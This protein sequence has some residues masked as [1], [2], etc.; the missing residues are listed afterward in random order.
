MLKDLSLALRNIRR[1]KVLTAINVLG[2]SIGISAC[3]AIFLIASYEL[4]FDKFQP[5]KDRI[6]RIYSEF[7]G[8]FK[9]S[10]R[11]VPT[12]VPVAIRDHL[13]GIESLTNFHNFF[14]CHVKIPVKNSPP[15]DFGKYKKVII[16]APDYFEVF[17]YYEWIVGNPK[18]SLSQPFNVVI[19][20]SRAMMYFGVAD[21]MSVIGKEI[22]YQDSLLV[23]V[24]GVVKDIRERTDLDFTDFISLST[25]ERSWLKDNIELNSWNNVS[26]SSQLFV[27]LAAG[28]PPEKIE[29]ELLRLPEILVAPNEKWDDWRPAAR[30]QPFDELHF[31][32]KL[33]VFDSSRTVMDQSTIYIL[34]GVAAL[35]LFTGII[36][37]INLQTAQ[38]SVHAKEVGI[39][40]LM[41]SSRTKLISRFLSQSLILCALAVILSVPSVKLF[42]NYFPDYIPE[43]LQFHLADPAIILFLVSC[44]IAVTFLAGLYPAFVMSSYQPA[45][46]L[47][48][49]AHANTGS[50]RSSFIRKSLTLSQFSFSQIFLAGALVIALQLNYMVNKDLGFDPN[51]VLYVNT[52]EINKDMRQMFANALDQIP[53]IEAFGAHSSPPVSGA[54]F[55][56]SYKYDNGKD[57]LEHRVEMKEGDTSYL[58]IYGIELLAGR[59]VLPIDSVREVVINEKYMHVLGFTDAREVIG[60]TLENGIDIVGV[61]RDFH[62]ESLH[63]AI[64]P[65]AISFSTKVSGF[66]IKLATPNDKVGDLGPALSKI[67]VAWKKLFPD[68]EFKVSFMSDTMKRYYENEQRTGKIAAMSSVIAILISCLGLFGLSSFTV[69]RRTKEIGIRK[70]LGASVNNILML[71]SGDSLKLMF[72][73][74]VLSAPIA[75]Y[76][77]DK[78]LQSFAYRMELSAWIFVLSG[79]FSVVIA[80]TTISFHTINAAKA[81]PVKSLRYE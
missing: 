2:L 1:N 51:A 76:F 39:R 77:A 45:L 29:N 56:N 13:T 31:N 15:K 67:E 63:T 52:Y 4:G 10:N 28:T 71:L 24:S 30:M 11:G 25:V 58:R 66:G 41:G 69:I 72:I 18:Q 35:L 70:V 73:A 20:E 26:S 8:Q 37:F 21:P 33:G 22:V 40:K 6:Y 38:A 9:G 79:L 53:E 5:D 27:K 64:G 59:N 12:A 68:Q 48:N 34:I 62:T 55:F 60:E 47:K 44:I 54:R 7:S 65:A 80:F 57:I 49:L 14:D 78:W 50:S 19:S 42:F 75:Y 23:T 81:D 74:F 61:V 17:N 3:L 36:N 16:T 32:S 43:G 46:A